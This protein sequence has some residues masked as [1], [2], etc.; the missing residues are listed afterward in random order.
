MSI[1]GKKTSPVRRLLL[2]AA[3]LACPGAGQAQPALVYKRLASDIT[4]RADGSFSQTTR[5]EIRIAAPEGVAQ[6]QAVPVDYNAGLD[7]L[8]ILEAYTLKPDGKKIPVDPKT[9]GERQVARAEQMPIFADHRQKTISFAGAAPNDVIVWS[10]QRERKAPLLPGLFM[11]AGFFPRISAFD[12][13]EL[14]VR[15]PKTLPLTID[16]PEV[17]QETETNADGFVYHLRYAAPSAAASDPAALSAYDRLP[18]YFI[19]SFA[20]YDALAHAYAGLVNPAISVSPAVQDF[21]DRITAQSTDR[22]E[23]A[24]KLYEWVATR[25]NYV[26][27]LVGDGALAP[28]GPN[29]I[30][31]NRAGDS[32]DQAVLLCALLK[33]KGIEAEVALVNASN[34]YTLAKAPTFTQLDHALVW[35]PDW[36]IYAD[37]STAAAPLGVLPPEEYG[38]PV[39]HLVADGTALHT[40]P[41]LAPNAATVSLK[42]VE[43][44]SGEGKVSGS[45][46]TVATGP[47]ATALRRY[48]LAFRRVGMDAAAKAELQSLGTP[49]S[50]SFEPGRVDLLTPDFKMAGT[51]TL[52]PLAPRKAGDGYIVPAGLRLLA[53][54]G[55]VLMGP[56]SLAELGESEPTPCYS[57]HET[58]ELELKLPEGKRVAALPAATEIK[59]GNL[60]YS[61]HWTMKGQTLLVQREFVTTIDEPLCHGKVR[62]EAAG[63]LKKI[64][65]DYAA[66]IVL[67]GE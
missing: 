15:S 26:S 29:A 37:T 44:L 61:S 13:V 60:Q 35:L 40:T 24:A 16:S 32:L 31:K 33:A 48:A 23:Q 28:H 59:T 50:G 41:L 49:G 20:S 45:S 2:I 17:T 47:F 64:R 55:E 19:S 5:T 18:R 66:K 25:I 22:K 30:L 58:E 62:A 52:D 65:E 43:T 38:K 21:A 51:F 53:R 57:G 56:L 11:T 67:T 3:L 10:V 34:S 63:A 4:V 8:T 54:P 36:K 1:R 46:V 12:A 27:R 9:I 39:L 6:I 7:R 42:T 14:T